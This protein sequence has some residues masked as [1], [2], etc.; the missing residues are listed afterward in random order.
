MSKFKIQIQIEN[1]NISIQTKR[2]EQVNINNKSLKRRSLK[3]D[4]E[5][6]DNSRNKKYSNSTKNNIISYSYIKRNIVEILKKKVN[7]I[8]L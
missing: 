7:K 4:Y 8:K 1:K 5:D 2:E 6:K 3:N